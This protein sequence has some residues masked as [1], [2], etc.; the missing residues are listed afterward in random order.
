M[1]SRGFEVNVV[2]TTGAG[3]VFDAAFNVSYINTG[4]IED[5]LRFASIAA[6][7]KVT[8]LGGVSSPKLEEVV[9]MLKDVNINVK[10]R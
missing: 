5:S 8:K 4:S 2:D 7:L 1:Q 3:D 9:K 6:G 10:C